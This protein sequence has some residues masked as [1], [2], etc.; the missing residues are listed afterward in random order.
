MCSE[1]VPWGGLPGLGRKRVP[2]LFVVPTPIGNLEDITLRAL[3]VMKEVS[4]IFAEDTRHT[5]KLLTHYGIQTPLQSYHQHNKRAR[6]PAVLSALQEADVALVSSAGMP[7]ISDPGY[8]LVAAAVDG[9][10][11]VDVLPGPSAAM[12]AVVGAAIP[13]PGFL[14]LGFL[15]RRGNDRRAVLTGVIASPYALVVYEAPHRLL[16]TLHAVHQVLG[17][18]HVVAARELTKIHQEYVRGSTAELIVHFEGRQ[19]RGECTLVI[20]GTAVQAPDRTAEAREEL[21]RRHRQGEEA[22][23][24]VAEVAGL[25]GMQRNAVYRLWLETVGG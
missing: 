19:P 10:I 11:D 12:T 14:F 7:A 5:R 25:L 15:P 6:I 2:S 24:A 22:R 20:A 23:T 1:G 16:D 8:E 3:R 21:L 9:G 17:D 4:V 13:A 18:R